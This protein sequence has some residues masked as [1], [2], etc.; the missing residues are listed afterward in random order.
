M[1]RFSKLTAL[2]SAG[3]LLFGGLFLSC[4]DDGGDDDPVLKEIVAGGAPTALT[5]GDN[6]A[7]GTVKVYAY[8][9]NATVG[10]FSE[11][12][13]A[14]KDVTS[15][16]TYTASDSAN[17]VLKVGEAV[18]LAA[19]TY[20]ITVTYGGKTAATKLSLTVSAASD[21]GLSAFVDSNTATLV[22]TAW[23]DA[24]NQGTD[25]VELAANESITYTFKVAEDGADCLVEAYDSAADP[26]YLST[27]SQLTAWG[28]LLTAEAG[29]Q[30]LGTLKATNI[31]SAKIAYD[32]T[33]ISVVYT[34]LGTSGS[35]STELFSVT[36]DKTVTAP[37]KAHLVAEWNTFYVKSEK[38]EAS[39]GAT[40]TWDFS[41]QPEGFPTSDAAADAVTDLA[42]PVTSGTGASLTATGRWKWNTDHLQAQA[43]SGKTVADAPTW[44]ETSGGKWL[45][46]TLDTDSKV[47]IVY[48][49]AGGADAKRFIAI[50]A[51][52]GTE[53]LAEGNLGND[54]VTKEFDS[55]PAGT[56]TIPMN[57][58]SL[59]SITCE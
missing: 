57:G 44:T 37:V 13:A 58:S 54:K 2:L 9:D 15:D 51:A 56:Y 47:T 10:T 45:T 46:F 16:A 25:V 36:T 41:T 6:F 20:E 19:G 12:G 7:L 29:T 55:V 14:G 3:A 39:S 42:V 35:E 30:S 11:P 17:T 8:Y 23:W 52:D 18:N 1:K 49:G 21:N 59:F 22:G 32:G 34:D 31:Y 26:L 27:T 38:T 48:S 28:G 5:V 50:Y 24:A 33:A 43:S 53:I 4:S 40:A